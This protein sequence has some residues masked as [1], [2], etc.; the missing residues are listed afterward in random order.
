MNEL[1]AIFERRLKFYSDI[2][3]LMHTLRFSE[4]GG[5]DGVAPQ[6]VL[7]SITLKL[8]STTIAVWLKF[9]FSPYG[10]SYYT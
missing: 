10:R 5:G 9:R 3:A 1:G 8:V 7:L 4:I 6:H 2:M